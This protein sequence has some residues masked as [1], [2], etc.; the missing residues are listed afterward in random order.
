MPCLPLTRI[1][2]FVSRDSFGSKPSEIRGALRF[3]DSPAKGSPQLTKRKGMGWVKSNSVSSLMF[4]P[5]AEYEWGY[6]HL[7]GTFWYHKYLLDFGCQQQIAG[8]D[9]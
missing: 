5:F 1:A 7:F 8:F 6:E 4:F 2:V 3:V 9:D